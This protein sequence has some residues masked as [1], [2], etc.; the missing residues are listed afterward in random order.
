MSRRSLFNLTVA[1]VTAFMAAVCG[2]TAATEGGCSSVLDRLDGVAALTDPGA[3]SFALD[4]LWND[5]A[6]SGR[7]PCVAGDSVVF[8]YRGE[9]RSVTFTGDFDGWNPEPPRARRLP[10]TELWRQVEVFPPDARLDYKIVVDGRTWLLDPMNPRTQRGGFGDNSELRMPDYRPSLWVASRTD[11]PHGGLDRARLA[12]SALDCT[13]ELVIYTPPGY[14]ALDSLPVIYVT[15][16]HEY[17]DPR[18]GAM[19]N[20]MDNLIAAG[21]LRPIAAVFIDPRVGGR[22]RRAEQYV[23]NEDFLRFVR[24]E[25]VPWTDGRLRAS[26]DRRDRGILGTS[27][28]GLNAAWFALK[29]PEIFGRAG[30]Q[31]PAFQAGDGR[32]YGMLAQAPRLDDDLFITWGT[33]HDTGP[34][35]VPFL[36]ILDRRGIP[37]RS[38]MVNEGHSWG[39]WRAQLDDI[40]TAFWPAR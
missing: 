4:V 18:M 34:A 7:I 11:I 13:V 29:A 1:A 37:Y 6:A 30:I 25:L 20:V 9:A 10:G 12:S 40:L 19:V 23:L 24:D 28:G 32:I 14:A 31:S 3:R 8:L 26:A 33:M 38:L 17:A 21:R 5:L 2:A 36:E 16:G 27:L 39:A 15:D 35:V 22:N